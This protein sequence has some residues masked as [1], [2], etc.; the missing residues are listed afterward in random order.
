MPGIYTNMSRLSRER[1]KRIDTQGGMIVFEL[2]FVLVIIS[3]LLTILLP[4]V[5]ESIQIAKETA[6][7]VETR[8]VTI[9]LQSLLIMTYG[10]EITDEDTG[11]PL[12]LADLTYF[13]IADR[14][15]VKLTYKAYREMKQLSG[16]DFGV[17]ENVVLKNRITLYSF[18]YYTPNGSIV[19]YNNGRY[20]VTKLYQIQV[21]EE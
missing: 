4:K 15:N 19:D 12:T 3:L 14:S 18:R 6:E 9:S 17:V 1:V 8:M 7:I 10:N 13:D 20:S 2:L 21:T 11:D 16:V 5:L